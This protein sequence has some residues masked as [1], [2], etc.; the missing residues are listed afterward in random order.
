MIR[1]TTI[2]YDFLPVLIFRFFFMGSPLSPV[3]ANLYMEYFE[4]M[5]LGS[6]SLKPSTWLRYVDDT[7]ILRP[8]QEDVQILLDHV[9]SI[10]LSIQFILEKEQDNKLTFL[11]VL[12]ACTEQGF[13]LLVYRE[14][15]FTGQYLN[16]NSHHPYTVKKGIVAYNIEQKL[17]VAILMHIKKKWLVWDT[18]SIVTTTQSA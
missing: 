14:P 7:F 11:D 5:P 2:M 4:E 12:V 13:R 15:T 6:T 10:R 8:Q 17:L 3:L 16:F 9:N 18:T 1:M